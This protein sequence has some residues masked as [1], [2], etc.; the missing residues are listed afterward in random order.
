MRNILST[1]P[2]DRPTY[3][4]CPECGYYQPVAPTCCECA[5]GFWV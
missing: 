2:L 3:V 1:T 4:T 5:H